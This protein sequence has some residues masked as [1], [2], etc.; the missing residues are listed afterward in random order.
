MH[1]LG[2]ISGEISHISTNVQTEAGAY[3]A[4]YTLVSAVIS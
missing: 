1:D 2:S 4:S 3:P